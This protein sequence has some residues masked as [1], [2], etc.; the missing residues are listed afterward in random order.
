M[1]KNDIS[2]IAQMLIIND[3]SLLLYVI[4]FFWGTSN[5]T[6][7]GAYFPVVSDVVSEETQGQVFGT[8]WSLN[9]LT[10]VIVPAVSGFILAISFTLPLTI[11]CIAFLAALL[12]FLLWKKA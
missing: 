6:L 7:Y 1:H 8:M 2:I 3:S 10:Q 5:G 12:F 11:G 9:S 4:L